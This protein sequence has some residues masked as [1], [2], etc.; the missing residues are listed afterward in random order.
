MKSKTKSLVYFLS[1]SAG[2]H[3]ETTS[4]KLSWIS[5]VEDGFHCVS[6]QRHATMPAGEFQALSAFHESFRIHFIGVA[7]G[8]A[9]R[10]PNYAFVLSNLVQ[11]VYI[12]KERKL[13]KRLHFI[14]A[15]GRQSVHLLKRAITELRKIFKSL[16][17]KLYEI[18]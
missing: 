18:R 17:I 16:F 1:C 7:S 2:L 13:R 15:R 14:N 10:S 11:R 3:R 4:S 8:E 9:L 6:L 5:S 12:I